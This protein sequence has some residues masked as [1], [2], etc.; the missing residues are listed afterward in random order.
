MPSE[1]AVP[2]DYAVDPAA[3]LAYGRMWGT[4]TGDDMLALITAVH[5]DPRWENGFDAIWD[6]SRVHAHIVD[7]SEVG[8]LI[9]EEAASGDGHD[10]L[11]ESPR[12]AEIALAHLLAAFSRRRGKQV[13]V[14]MDVDDALD[15]L[16]RDTLPAVLDAL[17]VTAPA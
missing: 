16:G 6:C 11:I 3:R 8:P 10:V 1:P 17:R 12:L 5:N 13:T 4:V 7:I 2:Y 9:D 14:H 15:A